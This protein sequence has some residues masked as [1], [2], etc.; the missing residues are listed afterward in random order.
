M[1]NNLHKGR[2]NHKRS[3]QTAVLPTPW[4]FFFCYLTWSYLTFHF[5]FLQI[6][7]LKRLWILINLDLSKLNFLS[8]FSLSLFYPKEHKTSP[9]PEV[10]VPYSQHQRN[11]HLGSKVVNKLEALPLTFI[12]V[13][14]TPQ[15]SVKDEQVTLWFIF[16]LL[17]P[18]EGR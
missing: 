11:L 9:L 4:T 17:L 1:D 8:V 15:C 18:S 2:R 5:S 16:F 3:S 12:Q 13:R 10:F 6:H 14:L 7:A